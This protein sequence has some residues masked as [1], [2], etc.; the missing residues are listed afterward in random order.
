MQR[1]LFNMKLSWLRIN[2][3]RWIQYIG[4]IS[5]SK[6]S[7]AFNDAT[8]SLP[9]WNLEGQRGNRTNRKQNQ[10]RVS[11]S[12]LTSMSLKLVRPTTAFPNKPAHSERITARVSIRKCEVE[13]RRYMN[14]V[15]I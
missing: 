6:S 3:S 13:V 4:L 9:L 15:S 10:S 5:I 11:H 2:S 1:L 14:T 8:R 12:L 7:S